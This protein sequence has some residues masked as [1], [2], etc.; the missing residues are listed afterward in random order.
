MDYNLWKIRANASKAINIEYFV[1]GKGFSTLPFFIT[2]AL[3]IFKH[4]GYSFHGPIETCTKNNNNIK[5][6]GLFY[7]LKNS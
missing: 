1:S 6:S 4:F 5:S 3:M 7:I 2:R